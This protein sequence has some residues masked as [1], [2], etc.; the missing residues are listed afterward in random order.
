M[1]APYEKTIFETV[2]DGIIV[3][4]SNGTIQSVNSAA[5][6]ITGYKVEELVGKN[7]RILDCT[8]C[9]IIDDKKSGVW[10]GLFV[11]GGIREKRCQLRT[12]DGKIL[13][14]SKNASIIKDKEGKAVGAV[15]T[16]TDITDSIQKEKQIKQLKRAL[17]YEYSFHGII[18]RSP[19]MMNLFQNREV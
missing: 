6:K 2:H 11:R 18:G 16:I 8:G 3:V 14:I 19:K 9:K 15:E 5:E 12:K 17:D 10:C 13:Q 1:L 7:C 4:D